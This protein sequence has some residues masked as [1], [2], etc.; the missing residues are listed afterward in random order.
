MNLKLTKNQ[1]KRPKTSQK[2]LK[3]SQNEPKGDLK[4]AQTTENKP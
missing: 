4:G 1:P 3:T 2:Q